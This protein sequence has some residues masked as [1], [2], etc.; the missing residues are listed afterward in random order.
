[1][2]PNILFILTDDQRCDTIHALGN[3]EIQT[4]HLDA[5]VARGTTFT[6]AHIPGG[7]CAAICMPSRAMI[8]TGR[9]LFHLDRVGQ[10]LPA[11]H[12]TL[13]ETFRQAGYETYHV[14]KWHN[15]RPGF[16]RSFTGGDEIFF[17]GMWDHWNV[18]AYRF[19]PTG[20][21]DSQLPMIENIWTS[22]KITLRGGDHVTAGRHSTELF[23]DAAMNFLRQR[24][25][26]RPFYLN[27][28]F[29]APHDPRTMPERFRA[30]YDPA[31]ISLPANFLPEHPFDTGN[32]RV[33]DEL[34]AAF[35]RTPEEIRRHIA[36]YYAMISH[37]DDA[38]GRLLACLR[39][40]GQLD[41]TILVFAGDNG[42]AVGQ[43]G[44]MGKQNLY[45]HSIRVPL[46]FAGPGIPAGQRRD[47][48]VCLLDIFPTLCDL[49]GLPTPATVEGRNVFTHDREWLYLAC[50]DG[51]RGV[52][53]HRHKLIEYRQG[54][55]VFDLQADPLE[56]HNL[57]GDAALVAALRRELLRWRDE[58]GDLQ[59][60]TGQQFW[61]A[62]TR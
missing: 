1:V 56:R 58:S 40:T 60:P 21:Y 42:L 30:M 34:L 35:P 17:G 31:R 25:Q 22:N 57:A 28:A 14:G 50:C 52:K 9:A 8:H 13:G 33:R 27:L 20:K 5:L 36:E 61:S 46:I 39:E 51:I 55:Q 48:F 29:L 26:D 32:L 11:A 53:N 6:H 54:T 10:Q 15:G 4:P 38:L 44:L 62:W 18:P 19:D 41:N 49:T 7:T 24:R 16:V 3:D 23:L 37:L 12:A 43:H 47:A 2:K 59:H 45:E